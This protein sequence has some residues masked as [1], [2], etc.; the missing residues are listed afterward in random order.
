[1]NKTWLVV[2]EAAQNLS[3]AVWTRDSA[4]DVNALKVRWVDVSDPGQWVCQGT[5]SRASCLVLR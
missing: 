3:L 4:D 1:M 2:R 5:E